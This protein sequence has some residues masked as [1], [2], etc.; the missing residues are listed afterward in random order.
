MLKPVDQET[1]Q[2]AVKALKIDVP[3]YSAIK[4]E[5]GTI[6]IT[7]RNSIQ[8]WTPP[9]C[10]NAG[11]PKRKTQTP[12]KTPKTSRTKVHTSTGGKK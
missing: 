6:Q 7:T 11:R 4:M 8:T 3:I 9:A 5:D 1:L 2:A 12:R 10:Q